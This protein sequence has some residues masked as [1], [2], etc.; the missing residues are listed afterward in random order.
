MVGALLH[1]N[2]KCFL[3]FW[4][5]WIKRKDLSVLIGM[6]SDRNLRLWRFSKDLNDDVKESKRNSDPV[7]FENGI[8]FF[9]MC[10]F[11]I[12]LNFIFN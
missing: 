1:Q 5:L 9:L 12:N 7:C 3:I 4:Y 11:G 2:F 6:K 8:F 10:D